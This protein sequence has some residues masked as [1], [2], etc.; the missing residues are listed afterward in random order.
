M[1]AQCVTEFGSTYRTAS[2]LDVAYNIK[3]NGYSPGAYINTSD[4]L[5]CY[6]AFDN[7]VTGNNYWYINWSSN[8]CI[9]ANII[10]A[11]IHSSTPTQFTRNAYSNNTQANKDAGCTTEFGA[12]FRNMSSLDFVANY[13]SHSDPQI[14]SYLALSDSGDNWATTFTLST[15]A[16]G[17][18]IKPNMNSNLP[19]NYFIPCIAY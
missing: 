15:G 17:S 9:G 6:R 1:D 4:N 2:T 16:Y 8:I 19:G 5:G 14:F 3:A 18:L 11:C 10:V 7:L 13:L 12:G